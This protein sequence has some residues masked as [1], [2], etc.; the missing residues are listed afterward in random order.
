MTSVAL[1][2]LTSPFGTYRANA[3]SRFFW[4]LADRHELAVALRRRLRALVARRFA[5]P[6]DAEAEGLRFRLYPGSNYDDRKIL[7]K[8][9]LPERAE[10]RL[11]APY[12]RDGAIF[13]DV[14]ANVGSHALVAASRGARVIAIE[15]NPATA[16]RLAFNAAA[17]GL[18]NVEIVRVAVGAEAGRLELWSEPTNCG[19]ATLLPELTTGEWAGDWLPRD[20]EVRPLADILSAR[21]IGR[22]DLLKVD[23]E[24]FEDRALIPYLATTGPEL[25][26]SAIMIETNCRDHWQTDC[27]AVLADLGYRAVGATSDNTVFERSA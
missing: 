18:D 27:F 9:R 14:G 1:P 25:R 10:H 8:G 24:G 2:D 11:V 13:V 3:V 6:Y 26:P 5:G 4:W 19:F 20:V 12:L 16:D 21:G 23:V 22:V 15:A 17:N 7:A